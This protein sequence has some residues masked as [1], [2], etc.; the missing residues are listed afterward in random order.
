MNS[1]EDQ[2]A[3]A[4]FADVLLPLRYAN[5]RGG[6]DYLDRGNR[7][8][9]YW[10]VVKSRTGGMQRLPAC[11]VPSLL[12]L[13]GSYWQRG[14]APILARMLPDLLELY[15]KL[16]AVPGDDGAEPPVSDFVYPLA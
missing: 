1:T 11:D 13:L 8:S 7:R 2:V 5:L 4:F 14:D 6:T 10:S 9:S 3:A 16:N 15:R 12:R